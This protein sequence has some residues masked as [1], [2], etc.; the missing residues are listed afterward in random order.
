MLARLIPQLYL[1]DHA[2][3]WS[4]GYPALMLTDTVPLRNPHYHQPTDL[5]ET[6]D[7]TFLA[8]VARAVIGT[9]YDWAGE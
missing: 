1:S 9:V 8:D 5:P 3:F 4:E 6:L 2:A 7:Y